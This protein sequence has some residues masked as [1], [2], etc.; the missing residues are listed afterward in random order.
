MMGKTNEANKHVKEPLKKEQTEPTE[1]QKK[2]V[3]EKKGHKI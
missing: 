3:Q 1:K 2:E